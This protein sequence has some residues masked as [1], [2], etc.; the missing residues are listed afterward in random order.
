M[1]AACPY[2]GATASIVRNP[3]YG[4]GLAVHETI[5]DCNECRR[6]RLQ[7]ERREPVA[8]PAPAPAGRRR[9]FGILRPQWV[10]VHAR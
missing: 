4:T 10:A 2:C 3:F 6:V 1:R 7:G 5:V 8:Q 9:L